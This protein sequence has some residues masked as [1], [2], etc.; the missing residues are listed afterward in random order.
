VLHCFQYDNGRSAA[1]LKNPIQNR[2]AGNESCLRYF[3][4]QCLKGKSEFR[5]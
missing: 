2:A 5:L 4:G 3:G 1:I